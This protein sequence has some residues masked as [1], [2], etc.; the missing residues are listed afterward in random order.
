MEDFSG[1][2]KLGQLAGAY[3]GHDSN[4]KE[5]LMQWLHMNTITE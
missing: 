3:V 1:E 5:R 4:K 2:N